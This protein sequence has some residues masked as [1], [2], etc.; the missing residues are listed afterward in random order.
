MLSNLLYCQGQVVGSGL[1]SDLEAEWKKLYP[2]SLLTA[3]LLSNIDDGFEGTRRSTISVILISPIQNDKIGNIIES[4]YDVC[5]NLKS[6]LTVYQ[7]TH[8]ERSAPRQPMQV[9]HHHH[10][11]HHCYHYHSHCHRRFIVIHQIRMI[12][13][14]HVDNTGEGL[15]GFSPT[16]SCEDKIL[17]GPLSTPL[18]DGTGALGQ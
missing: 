16:T 4:L 12:R 18:K 10:H 11:H 13:Y 5:R 6:R 1:T 3:R 2:A 15:P 9:L 17:P 14:D 7:R 8:A